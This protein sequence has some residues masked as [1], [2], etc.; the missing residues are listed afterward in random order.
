M[1]PP[2]LRQQTSNCSL[3]LI[4][5]PRKDERLSWPGS[6]TYSGWF[7]WS[8]VSYRSSAGQGKFAG[9]R[10][11][12][13]RCATRPTILIT[14]LRNRS[15]GEIIRAAVGVCTVP[16]CDDVCRIT[17][18]TLKV[19]QSDVFRAQLATKSSVVGADNVDDLLVAVDVQHFV[20]ARVPQSSFTAF[21]SFNNSAAAAE[22]GDRLITLDIVR[23]LGALCSFVSLG[24]SF[25]GG[26]FGSPSETMWRGPRTYLRT[27]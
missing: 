26:G 19:L 18:D 8:P 10:P 24:D 13:Y 14:I 20:L 5:R 16:G 17:R 22:M 15:C 4:Y 6:L 21:R 9:Q 27:K 1:A 3:L 25:F 11:T 7:Q 23:N 2:Q 12:F